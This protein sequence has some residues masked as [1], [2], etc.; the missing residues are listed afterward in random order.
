MQKMTSSTPYLIRAFYDWITDNKMTPYI[1]LNANCP[2][3]KVPKQYVK[4]GKIILNIAVTAVER[5]EL[6]NHKIEFRASFQGKLQNVLAPIAA[7]LAIYAKE[8][9]EGTSFPEIPFSD[10]DNWEFDENLDFETKTLKS[11][12]EKKVSHLRLVK[13]NNNSENKSD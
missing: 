4:D 5:L 8:T 10:E 12:S 2:G 9:G 11:E 13:N 7:V 1:V 3:V 6:A